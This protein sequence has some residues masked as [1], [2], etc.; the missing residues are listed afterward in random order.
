MACG[1]IY[2]SQRATTAPDRGTPCVGQAVELAVRLDD[3]LEALRARRALLACRHRMAYARNAAAT[4][5]SVGPRPPSPRDAPKHILA[6]GCGISSTKKDAPPPALVSD[7][8]SW[9]ASRGCSIERHVGRCHPGVI[10]Y[11]TSGTQDLCTLIPCQ[12]VGGPVGLP[13]WCK[14]RAA[15]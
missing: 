13:G 9:L 7:E 1:T 15:V 3:A 14:V 2:I 4:Q 10:S 11:S 8:R 5:A 12:A 6:L